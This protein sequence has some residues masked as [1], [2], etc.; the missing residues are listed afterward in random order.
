MRR[1]N[2]TEKTIKKKRRRKKHYRLRFIICLLICVGLYFIS[3]IDYFTVDGIA[4]AGNEEVS[5]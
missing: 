2:R 4:V 5:D 3:H 1:D